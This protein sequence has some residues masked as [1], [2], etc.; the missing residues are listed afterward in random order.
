MGS[1]KRVVVTIP[2]DVL[3]DVTFVKERLFSEKPYAEM[4]RQ[5]IQMGLTVHRASKA[6]EDQASE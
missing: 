6:E 4:Y 3:A 2:Q 1:G 5:L